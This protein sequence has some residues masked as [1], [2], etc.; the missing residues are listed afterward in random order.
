MEHR[1]ELLIPTIERKADGM[2]KVHRHC[3]LGFELRFGF[4]LHA[5][6]L[7]MV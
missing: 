6:G 3:L 2:H 5:F 7:H 4:A 1:R